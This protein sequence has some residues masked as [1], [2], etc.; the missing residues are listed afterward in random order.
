MGLYRLAER[1]MVSGVLAG[2]AEKYSWDVSVV[3]LA[4]VFLT[5]F[6]GIWPGVVTY[7]AGAVIIPDKRQVSQ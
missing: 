2:I 4:A 3:R 6:T 5:I 7:I 1:K